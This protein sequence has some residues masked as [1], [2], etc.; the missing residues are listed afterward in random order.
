MDLN[1]L[2]ALQGVHVLRNT[3]TKC[4]YT[5]ST[6]KTLIYFS[7]NERINQKVRR[8]E[9]RSI[10]E[11][12]LQGSTLR[13]ILYRHRENRNYVHNF[14][15]SSTKSFNQHQIF[16]YFFSSCSVGNVAA[17]T[18]ADALFRFTLF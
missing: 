12:Q 1:E 7:I 15:V 10:L 18:I 16:A 6:T 3:R 5:L 14:C 13:S 4:I 2:N 11:P 9:C 8:K 17:A